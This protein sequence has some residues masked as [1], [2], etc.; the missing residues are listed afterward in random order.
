MTVNI[1]STTVW[2]AAAL[3]QQDV[4]LA[5]LIPRATI[6]VAVTSAVTAATSV[7]DTL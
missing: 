7:P 4:I 2:I 1:A 3:G 6:R 5:P